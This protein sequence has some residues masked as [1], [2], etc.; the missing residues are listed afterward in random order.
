M[1]RGC[2]RTYSVSEATETKVIDELVANV[3]LR[4]LQYVK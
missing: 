3:D 4:Q 2:M 1:C